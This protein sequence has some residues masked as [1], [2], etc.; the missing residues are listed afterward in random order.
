MRGTYADL[1]KELMASKDEIKLQEK[2]LTEL[3]QYT[4]NL[5]LQLHSRDKEL[6]ILNKGTEDWTGPVKKAVETVNQ[7][8]EGP[9]VDPDELV[10]KERLRDC[11]QELF[12]RPF[13]FYSSY[14]NLSQKN[15]ELILSTDMAKYYQ[16]KIIELQEEIM[17]GESELLVTRLGQ[18]EQLDEIDKHKNEAARL[19]DDLT[20]ALYELNQ[21]REKNA[22]AAVRHEQEKKAIIDAFTRRIDEMK[23][24]SAAESLVKDKVI[25]KIELEKKELQT[26]IK[27]LAAILKVPRVHHAYIRDHGVEDFVNRC[28]SVVHYHDL[29]NEEFEYS[30]MRYK[31]RHKESIEKAGDPIIHDSDFKRAKKEYNV[32]LKKI[33]FI[34]QYPDQEQEGAGLRR[35]ASKT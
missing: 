9:T 10:V 25:E 17:V 5:E 2:I 18:E 12:E 1:D 27:E 19:K 31:A 8:I 11:A 20:I 26:K 7:L 3:R 22:M 21:E 16:A 6:S 14:V 28:R 34:V 33:P 23:K 15:K 4:R 30:Q 32:A 24:V 13:H 29:K 35:K